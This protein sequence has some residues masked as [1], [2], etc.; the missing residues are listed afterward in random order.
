MHKTVRTVQAYYTETV[1]IRWF[2]EDGIYS[3]EYTCPPKET[4]KVR[5]E[6]IK[7]PSE[8]TENSEK[9]NEIPE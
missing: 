8:T 7:I 2:T 6:K 5:N 1:L 4:R 9:S 3:Q